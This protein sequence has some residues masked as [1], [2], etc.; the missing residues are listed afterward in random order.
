MYSYLDAF[1]MLLH[2]QRCKD[3]LIG[4]LFYLL[5]FILQVMLLFLT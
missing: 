2:I 5:G 4:G 3:I 1:Q